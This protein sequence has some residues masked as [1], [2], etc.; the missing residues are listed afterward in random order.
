MK[1][2]LQWTGNNGIKMSDFIPQAFI[3]G[4]DNSLKIEMNGKTILAKTGD[5]IIKENQK[6]SIEKNETKNIK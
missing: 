6:L 5:W 2:K 4:D 1:E 3:S